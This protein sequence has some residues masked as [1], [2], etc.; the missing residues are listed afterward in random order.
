MQSN[1]E[2]EKLSIGEL[3]DLVVTN[4]PNVIQ[5]VKLLNKKA[6]QNNINHNRL[7][8]NQIIC[9]DI[10]EY[11]NRLE[12]L[13]S[14]SNE[15]QSKKRSIGPNSWFYDFMSKKPWQNYLRDIEEVFDDY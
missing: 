14:L 2:L 11:S 13:E 12:M 5:L 15:F 9:R 3:Q 10:R 6:I 1:E 7:R 4:P 8:E